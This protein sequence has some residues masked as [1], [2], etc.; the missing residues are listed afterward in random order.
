VRVKLADAGSCALDVAAEPLVSSLSSWFG[1]GEDLDL[2]GVGLDLVLKF[3]DLCGVVASAVLDL[4]S[5]HGGPV[6]ELG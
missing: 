6:A 2:P 4:A 1:Q 3:G 5:E